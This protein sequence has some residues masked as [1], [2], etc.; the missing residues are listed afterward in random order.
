LSSE[1]TSTE[2][3]DA[4]F[5]DVPGFDTVPVYANPRTPVPWLDQYIFNPV[6][7]FLFSRAQS[8]DARLWIR[9]AEP[10]PIDAVSWTALCDTP[11]PPTWIRLSEQAPVSTVTYSVYYRASQADFASA[12]SEF[13]LLDSRAN[14]AQGG[15]VDQYTS[16]WS[17]SGAC[18]QTQ[19]MLW[20]WNAVS[21][22]SAARSGKIDSAAFGRGALTAASV[23]H[24]PR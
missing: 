12:G 7:G 1:R 3:K 13:C 2:L 9:D 10:R 4:R 6:S 14:L 16:V 18:S 23:I 24:P 21:P 11:F 17:A 8:M 15:Y 19:Q 22:V 20:F 5:P